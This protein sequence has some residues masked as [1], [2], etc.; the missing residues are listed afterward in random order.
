MVAHVHLW[1][2]GL[3]ISWPTL[4]LRL[5]NLFTVIAIVAGLVYFFGRLY[6]PVLRRLEPGWTFLKP[7]L[8]ILPLITGWLAAHPEASPLSYHAML[9][10]HVL[11]GV[12][13]FIALP[14]ARMLTFIHSPLTRWM[15]QAAWKAAEPS[16]AADPAP[17]AGA[18]EVHPS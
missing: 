8:L 9:L 16:P 15:P 18:P 7:L 10:F 3:G 6:S 1:E 13:L 4:P 17:I 2:R 11:S 5:S 14:F 12:A